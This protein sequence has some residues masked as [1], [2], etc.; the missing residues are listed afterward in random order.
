LS[1]DI[2]GK[3]LEDYLALIFEK[4]FKGLAEVYYDYGKG[5]ADFILRFLDRTEIVI[6]VG[7]GKEAIKQ[8]EKTMSKTQNRA[9]YGI[10]IGA[11]QLDIINENIVKIPLDYFLLM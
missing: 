7:F 1:I 3:L 4:E 9:K 11:E 10:V 5:G 8:V 2:K 6:E